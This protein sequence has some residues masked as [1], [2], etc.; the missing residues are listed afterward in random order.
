M[1][2]SS[3]AAEGGS[4][5][6]PWLGIR[7]TRDEQDSYKPNWM[8]SGRVLLYHCRHEADGQMSAQLVVVDDEVRARHKPATL[9]E[10][11]WD[12]SRDWTVDET[13]CSVLQPG[14]G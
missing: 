7:G 2:R 4:A 3:A 9:E 6:P 10:A 5:C 14:Q 11:G 1:A 13:R 12:R 8:R